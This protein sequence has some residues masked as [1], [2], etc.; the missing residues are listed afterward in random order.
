MNAKQQT[1]AIRRNNNN[2]KIT[3]NK[4]KNKITLVGSSKGI[5][6]VGCASVDI[7]GSSI[8][9]Q[10]SVRH[11]GVH[12]DQVLSTK[13]HI[14]SLYCTAFLAIRKIASIR[15][16]LSDSSANKLVSSMII[17]KLDYCNTTFANIANEKI[18]RP[19]N[20]QE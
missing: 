12:L 4:N 7:G 2:N 1:E 16:F 14:N 17:S 3:K 8:P 9:F 19:Q 11:L 6:L 5:G 13:Q 15:P 18:A 20:N 10:S